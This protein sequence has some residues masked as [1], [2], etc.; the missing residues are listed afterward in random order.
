MS[1]SPVR[2]NSV[3]PGCLN[4]PN[5]TPSCRS[6]GLKKLK[7]L[8][9]CH[10]PRYTRNL[11][12][13]RNHIPHVPAGHFNTTRCV[14]TDIK[15]RTHDRSKH[16]NRFFFHL[17]FNSNFKP[18]TCG[19]P[20]PTHLP[21][22]VECCCT[23]ASRRRSRMVHSPMAGVWW[24]PL[25]TGIQVGGFSVSREPMLVFK[26]P[27]FLKRQVHLLGVDEVGSGFGWLVLCVR[28]VKKQP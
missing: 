27:F 4:P 20:T 19:T 17:H 23:A 2:A 6:E 12:E 16:K 15:T 21:I 7:P 26:V 25:G 14:H 24:H 28:G 11:W 5:P 18:V 9:P 10:Q 22:I 1:K 8:F 13:G 3:P